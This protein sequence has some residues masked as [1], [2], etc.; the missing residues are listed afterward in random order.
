VGFNRGKNARNTH[1]WACH[2]DSG[3]GEGKKGA[4]DNLDDDRYKR[5]QI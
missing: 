4:L 3:R 1:F 5:D 2:P